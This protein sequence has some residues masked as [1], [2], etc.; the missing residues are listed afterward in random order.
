M[1]A[2]AAVVDVAAVCLQ[3]ALQLRCQ[4]YSHLGHAYA[5]VRDKWSLLVNS[6]DLHASAATAQAATCMLACIECQHTLHVTIE[7]NDSE[8][9]KV[10]SGLS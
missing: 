2:A 8:G 5:Q 9:A 6:A 4:D 1:S 10:L 7:V 3:L